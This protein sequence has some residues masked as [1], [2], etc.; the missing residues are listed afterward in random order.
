[1]HLLRKLVFVLGVGFLL[2]SQVWAL[3]VGGS[4]LHSALNQPLKA[5]IEL[6]NLGDLQEDD[7]VVSLA[8]N[9][10]FER[11][12]I[13][14]LMFY[15]Q[16][17]FEL[18][19]DHE[20]GPKIRVTTREPVREPYLNFL[21]EL[22]WASGRLIREYTFLLDLPTFDD[23][24]GT[25]AGQAVEAAG[26]S[27][28]SA[29]REEPQG[30]RSAPTQ[31]RRDDAR[32]QARSSSA[33]SGGS[34]GPV[35]SSDTL[36]EIALQVRPDR[37]LSVQ[38]TM[39]ALQRRNPEAFI[40]GNINMLREGQI[41]RLPN[42]Q[43]IEAVSQRQAINQVAQHNR[44]WSA[45][46]TGAQLDASG[47]QAS[48]Q[49]AGGD[50]EGQL[51]LATPAQ[52][53]ANRAGQGGGA[54]DGE[55]Q[56]LASELAATR[57]ELDKTR[58]ENQE[59]AARVED[60]EA[61]IDT[62]ERLVEASNEQLRALQA[63]SE[64]N[65]QEQAGGQDA[66]TGDAGAAQSSA[67]P[68]SQ[69]TES[70]QQDPAAE[71]PSTAV[72]SQAG[73]TSE[74]S[75]RQVVRSIPQS[76]SWLDL[77]IDNLLWLAVAA[78]A[79]LLLIFYGYRRRSQ[80]EAVANDQGLVDSDEF[81]SEEPLALGPEQDLDYEQEPAS[82]E[83]DVS[84]ES[85]ELEQGQMDDADEDQIEAETG[86]AVAE[87]DI[88]IAY[89]KLEQAEELLLKELKKDPVAPAVL[90]KLLELY[91]ETQD[92]ER[93]DQHYATLLGTDDRAA[94]QRGGEL[95]EMIPGAAPFDVSALEQSSS[96]SESAASGRDQSM[97]LEGGAGDLD[98][99]LDEDFDFDLGELDE[100]AEKRTEPSLD[101]RDDWTLDPEP[102]ADVDNEESSAEVGSQ[103]PS[104]DADNEEPSAEV[105][106]EEPLAEA[107]NEKPSATDNEAFSSSENEPSA[108]GGEEPVYDLDTEDD[109]FSFDWEDSATAPKDS[110]TGSIEDDFPE[111]DVSL[112]ELPSSEEETVTGSVAEEAEPEQSQSAE[113]EDTDALDDWDLDLEPDEQSL[114]A[115][116]TELSDLDKLDD[117]PDQAQKE[118]HAQGEE[119][120]QDDEQDRGEEEAA[121]DETD[122]EFD[123]EAQPST[124]TREQAP[125]LEETLDSESELELP[126]LD[127]DLSDLDSHLEEEGSESQAEEPDLEAD[128]PQGQA[129][130]QSA[131]ETET[132]SED[133]DE[134]SVFEEAL[135]GL[136]EQSAQ[137]EGPNQEQAPEE[138]FEET[139]PEE[140][141]SDE[142]M[143]E[144]LDF[145][146]DAD[147]AATKL[148]LARAYIDMG[149]ADGA[150]DILEE[151]TREGDDQQKQEAQELLGRI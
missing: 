74:Q 47:R 28:R 145:L 58:R 149:D 85:Y 66:L 127:R 20:T 92:I 27:D 142:A 84:E 31:T 63:A 5:D 98:F 26:R 61:Q 83:T 3:G 68:Q 16:L 124:Q 64:Q 18:M 4:E 130:E 109:D 48:R 80:Q 132:S 25:T 9:A 45:N 94:I 137:A 135:S 121:S 89:G 115:L 148:D 105:G 42:R 111:L 126:D 151:V 144:E 21:L 52:E 114:S 139:R 65:R 122:A 119:Q 104:A 79:L 59:L 55:G 41:L 91:S 134:E 143:D 24:S 43:E 60:L 56:A 73:Q 34:Y 75:D 49:S 101:D 110:E 147:E 50:P 35:G 78:L 116:D 90:T 93:F 1:M 10:D 70:A 32:S 77:V 103:E 36:W 100:G 11:A 30:S 69:A 112:D 141:K 125:D 57:E 23:D 129:A 118:E 136:D 81:D 14:R 82:E 39:L 107:D 140:T 33:T 7:I 12:G 71:E 96:E 15:S 54:S 95:R 8:S 106:N 40:N 150:R 133:Q 13:D 17:N 97:D 117:A 76:K 120:P 131:Q 123:L 62:M 88:Y 113:A 72:Q 86:D 99:D 29:V 108:A 46:K 87:A 51:R 2:A 146:A 138:A 19:L 38:Q 22:R 37:D 102:S 128:F 67:E 6:T 53:T 44:D